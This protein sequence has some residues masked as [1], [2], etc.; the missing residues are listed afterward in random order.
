MIKKKICRKCNEELSI[1][2]FNKRGNGLS[3]WCKKCNKSYLEQYYLN[4]KD[5]IIIYVNK[6]KNNPEFTELPQEW[7][8]WKIKRGAVERGIEFKLTYQELC[9]SYTGFC[10]LSKDKIFCTRHDRQASNNQT[11]SLD[12]IN[13]NGGYTM[14]NIQW[15]HKNINFAKQ[16]LSNQDFIKMCQMVSKNNLTC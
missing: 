8:Y 4:H 1:D 6:Q 5:K 13:S 10:A 3:S 16:R 9:N 2:N 15:V 7:F 14:D 11:A 12:R